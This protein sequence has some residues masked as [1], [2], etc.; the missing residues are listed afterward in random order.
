MFSGTRG[1]L[2]GHTERKTRP[3]QTSRRAKRSQRHIKG[4]VSRIFYDRRFDGVHRE[5]M[6]T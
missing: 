4:N 1:P 3:R 5:M 2:A 6:D